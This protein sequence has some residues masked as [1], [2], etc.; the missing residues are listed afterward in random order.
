[1][2]GGILGYVES[3]E[4][5][6]IATDKNDVHFFALQVSSLESEWPEHERER[7]W[8]TVEDAIVRV[9]WRPEQ[10]SAL[11]H[12]VETRGP[13]SGVEGEMGDVSGDAGEEETDLALAGGVD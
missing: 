1:M 11:Q 3:P 5:C 6:Q 7:E 13:L 9:G 12:W 10:A 8:V 2:Q 4:I